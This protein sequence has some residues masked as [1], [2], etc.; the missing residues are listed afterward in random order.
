MKKGLEL[1]AKVFANAAVRAD[2]KASEYGT[3]QPKKPVRK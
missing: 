1:L 3:Y 2:G